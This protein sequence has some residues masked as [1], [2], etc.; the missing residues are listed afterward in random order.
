MRTIRKTLTPALIAMIASPAAAA[1]VG[2]GDEW[3]MPWHGYGHMMF[4]GLMMLAFWVLL[5]VAVVLAV[6][7]LMGT[8]G[9]APGAPHTSSALHILEE[10][11]ARG[12]IDCEE[13]EERKR[14]LSS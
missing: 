14:Q 6:R 10:R 3:F 5:I 4:G 13:F 2:G 9:H 8:T 1:P 11:Y 12:E 7:W